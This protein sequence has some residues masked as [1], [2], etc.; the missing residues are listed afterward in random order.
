MTINLIPFGVGGI[1]VYARVCVDIGNLPSNR[2]MSNTTRERS[3]AGKS[4][5]PLGLKLFPS[6]SQLPIQVNSKEVSSGIIN[7]TLSNLG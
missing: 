3:V 5:K 1:I 4:F 7:D 6:N 2:P